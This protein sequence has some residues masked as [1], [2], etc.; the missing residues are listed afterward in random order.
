[1]VWVEAGI[2]I[3]FVIVSGYLILSLGQSSNRN[4]F[5]R[6]RSTRD[7]SSN[8]Q[9][10]SSGN[11]SATGNSSSDTEESSSSVSIPGPSFQDISDSVGDKIT[12]AQKKKKA[13]L[14]QQEYLEEKIQELEDEETDFEQ[15]AEEI[16]E[17]PN[18]NTQ[19]KQ[20]L[21]NWVE[22]EEEF[23]AE[24]DRLYRLM[25]MTIEKELEEIERLISVEEFQEQTHRELEDIYQKNKKIDNQIVKIR[26]KLKELETTRE[27]IDAEMEEQSSGMYYD[28]EQHLKKL[29]ELNQEF[30][31]IYQ[32]LVEMEK[33][34]KNEVRPEAID[35]GKKLRKLEERLEQ[36]RAE[37]EELDSEIDKIGFET[38]P[39]NINFQKLMN[40]LTNDK[41]ESNI[42]LSSED[43]T[44]SIE[45][46]EYE[47]EYFD[48]TSLEIL[49]KF[50]QNEY[51]L[52]KFLEKTEHDEED[53]Q[54]IIEMIDEEEL[55]AL[56][57]EEESLS[58]ENR[59]TENI[60]ETLKNLIEEVR[61]DIE[62]INDREENIK[63]EWE[64]EL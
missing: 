7:T 63:E 43:L 25:R 15:A 5:R 12:K 46:L 10:S 9:V 3:G 2:I 35:A 11:S 48:P 16:M 59:E 55:K 1:M 60:E 53:L 31:E 18:I 42:D 45:E 61:Y 14:N 52:E 62:K 23:E 29:E 54:K 22:S 64:D 50:A 28:P 37:E 20:S 33:E 32:E 4:S 57:K 24:A 17:D 8:S 49:L 40:K 13:I 21:K 34:V 19:Y 38:T 51:D 26:E 30:K 58:K 44:K 41:F 6:D 47:S 36:E 27:Q 56:N 39:S